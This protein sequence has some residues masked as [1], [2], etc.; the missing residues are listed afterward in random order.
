[1]KKFGKVVMIQCCLEVTNNSLPSVPAILSNYP[2]MF[3]LKTYG[4]VS[5]TQWGIPETVLYCHIGAEGMIHV[6]KNYTE[7]VTNK[8]INIYAVYLTS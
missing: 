2:P 7:D 1:M 5:D 8:F 3:S 4:Y 6:A